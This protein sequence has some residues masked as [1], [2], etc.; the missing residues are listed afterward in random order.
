MS[1]VVKSCTA[2]TVAVAV[3]AVLKTASAQDAPSAT[4]PLEEITVTATRREESI[5]SVPISITAISGEALAEAGVKDTRDLVNFVPNLAQQGSFAHTSPSFFIR[6]VGSTQFNP[7]ANSKVGVYLDDVYL[8]SPAAHGSQIFDVATVEIA[9]GPQGTLFGQNTTA[10]LVRMITTR[11]DIGGGTTV[12]V[13]LT[14]GRFGQLDPEAAI[15]F[16]T[17]SNSAARLSVKHQVRDGFQ[18]NQLLGTDDGEVDSLGWRGQWLW[19]ASDDVSL[20]VLAHGSRDRSQLVP[21]KQVGLIDPTTF[22]PCA[23]PRAGGG[24]TDFFGYS[25]SADFHRGAWDVRDQYTDVKSFGGNVTLDWQLPAF[26][27]TSVT[28]YEE[29]ESRVH[30]DTDASPSYVMTGN[31]YGKPRQTSQEFRLT[32]PQGDLSWIA[33]AYY[34]HE[35]NDTSVGFPIPG[36]GPGALSGLSEVV[37]GL[38]QISSMDTDSYALFG[39]LDMLMSERIKL[40][41]GLRYT[42]E[43]KDVN[44]AAWLADVTDVTNTLLF[45]G[46]QITDRA[47]FQTIDFRADESWGD[48]SGRVSLSYSF[49]DDVLGYITVSRG[50]N[51]GNYNGGALSNQAEATLV[52]PETLRSYEVG[53][54]SEIGGQLRLNLSAFYYDFTDQQVF[55]LASG[56]AGVPVQQLSNA[57]A[58]TLYGLEMEATWH[59]LDDLVIQLGAGY[60]HSEFDEFNTPL[61]EDLSGRRLPSAPETNINAMATYTIRSALG[62]WAFEVDGKYQ[63]KQYFSVNND[64]ILSQ[65]AYALANA[66]VSWT[67]PSAHTSVTAWVR[68]LADKDYLVGAYDL[69]SFGWDQWVVGEPRTYGV[70]FE[71]HTR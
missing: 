58:S 67:S 43:T 61:G 59:P 69:A 4:A 71:Y 60:T 66:H 21:Y 56:D 12:D 1:S 18:R 48:V 10:G 15:G 29:N 54:K 35:T 2:M 5:Q 34:F 62:T 19:S 51:S 30:E 9:R 16:E 28:A 3:T 53:L 42:H 46:R 11:P 6:G 41:L 14:A 38:G 33:G 49:T 40:S 47:L 57:A 44:Y 52:D 70:T 63:S 26:T 7:N 37:E 22:E 55:V 32:S 36:F 64:P 31:Y 25:D 13:R 24:C 68:N 50:F 39:N 20:R 8:A 17:G 45:V 23:M 65:G 27:L